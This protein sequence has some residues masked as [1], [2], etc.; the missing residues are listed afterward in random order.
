MALPEGCAAAAFL[1]DRDSLCR[2]LEYPRGEVYQS[3]LGDE[4]AFYRILSDVVLQR[5]EYDWAQQTSLIRGG[6]DKRLKQ[7][8]RCLRELSDNNEADFQKAMAKLPESL[9]PNPIRYAN[10]VD[11]EVTVVAYVARQRGW[12]CDA[13]P[14]RIQDQILGRDIRL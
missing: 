10:V 1:G 11:C 8:W 7:L 3:P 9:A 13:F 6:F 4:L 12:S 14:Q 5:Q 2:F